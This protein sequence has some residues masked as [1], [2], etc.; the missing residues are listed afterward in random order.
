MKPPCEVV[1]KYLLPAARALIARKLIE[2]HGFTQVEAASKLGLTQSAMSRYIALERGQK[3]KNIKEVK[4]LIEDIAKN[5]TKS[6]LS[7]E[8]AILKLCGICTAFRKSGALCDF[9]KHTVPTLSKKCRICY[10]I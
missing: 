8:E 9:H 1:S 10:E 2:K 3:I 7:Q 6:Q 4:Q 5:I